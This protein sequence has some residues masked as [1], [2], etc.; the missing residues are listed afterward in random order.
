MQKISLV[1]LCDLARCHGA[2]LPAMAL[3]SASQH[4][5]EEREMAALQKGPGTGQ[6]RLSDNPLLGKLL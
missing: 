2:S 6:G 1:L 3:L 4:K 5:E